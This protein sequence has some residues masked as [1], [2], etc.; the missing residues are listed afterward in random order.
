MI[1]DDQEDYDDDEEEEEDGAG[2]DSDQL[3]GAPHG[4]VLRL[5][6][7][8]WENEQGEGRNCENK[9]QLGPIHPPNWTTCE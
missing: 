4:G 2:D 7:V 1:V 9:R 8:S 6:E 5:L 3:H